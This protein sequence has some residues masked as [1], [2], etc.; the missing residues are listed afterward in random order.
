MTPWTK[1]T[2]FKIFRGREGRKRGREEDVRKFTP[3]RLNFEFNERKCLLGAETA[4]HPFCFLK[5]KI[6]T[7]FI[8]FLK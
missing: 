1:N 5:N 2:G 3:L 7:F 8:L 6:E 4:P